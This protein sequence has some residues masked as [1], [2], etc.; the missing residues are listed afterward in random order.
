[1]DWL[2]LALIV[3]DLAAQFARWVERE[4]IRDEIEKARLR[5]LVEQINGEVAKANNAR[6]HVRAELSADPGK[7]RKPDDPFRRPD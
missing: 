2:K 3:L 4:K 6:A 7:L 5:E 1:M